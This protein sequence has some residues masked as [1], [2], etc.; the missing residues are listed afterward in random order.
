MMRE[1]ETRRE[2]RETKAGVQ[3]S[4]THGGSVTKCG[5]S[6]RAHNGGQLVDQPARTS[7]AAPCW[8]R[9]KERGG[10]GCEAATKRKAKV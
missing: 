3:V 10:G 1:R 9:Q 2:K 4:H 5:Q 8:G 7:P 6:I